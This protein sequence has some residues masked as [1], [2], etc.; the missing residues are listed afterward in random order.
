MRRATSYWLGALTAALLVTSSAAAERPSYTR[1]EGVRLA[2]Q[3]R[4]ALERIARRY[5]ERTGRRIHVTSG[6]RTP[7]EQADAM[8]EKLRRGQRLTRLY[9]DY[10]AAAAIQHAY[11]RHRRRGRRRC[12][13]AMARVIRE[14]VASG[15]YISRHLVSTAADVRSR[16]MTRRQRRIFRRVV[17]ELGEVSLLEEGTPPHFH[18]QLR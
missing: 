17:A 1:D 16:N 3:M 12:V 7:R 2:P 10:E 8:Y 5:H 9:R 4:R 15:C 14:Q 13:A 6:T 18:L 11:R